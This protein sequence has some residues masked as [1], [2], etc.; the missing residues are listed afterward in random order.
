MHRALQTADQLG[1]G[2]GGQVL[3]WLVCLGLVVLS[4]LFSGLTLGLLG[5][6]KTGLEIVI[7]GGTPEQRKHAKRLLPL[8]ADGNRLLC[9]L[10][11]GNV[12]VNAGLSIFLATLFSSVLGLVISTA[13]IVVFGEILPQATCS[14]HALKIGAHS[15]PAVRFFLILFAPAAVPLGW[16]LDRILG[17]D[18]GTVHT[19][20]E[21]LQYMQL[22]VQRGELDD[23]SGNVMKGALEM[24]SKS[25]HAVMTPLEDVYMLPDTT[26]LSFRVVRE[27]FE[28][29]FSRVPIFAGE[30]TRIVGLLFVKDLIFVDPEDETPI[31]S[32]LGIFHR[33]LQVVDE[34]NTLDDVLRIFKQGHGHLALVRAARRSPRGTRR[35]ARPLTKP[36]GENQSQYLFEQGDEIVGIVTLEDIVEEII[37]DEIIDETDVFVDVDNHVPVEGRDNFDFTKLR[38]LDAEFVTERLSPE[39]IQAV[40]AHLMTNVAQLREG[41][42]PART[43]KKDEMETLV[44]RSRVVDM[45]RNT[46]GRDLPLEKVHSK[47]FLYVHAESQTFATLVLSGKLTVLAGNDR[48]RSEAGP[49]TVLGADALVADEDS[50]LPDFSAFISTATVRCLF[51]ARADYARAITTAKP[52]VYVSDSEDAPQNRPLRRVG[53]STSR[54]DAHKERRVERTERRRQIIA[55]ADE[56]HTQKRPAFKRDKTATSVRISDAVTSNGDNNG[57]HQLLPSSVTVRSTG[58]SEADSSS[59]HY[60]HDADNPSRSHTPDLED[61]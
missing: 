30:R 13:L 55:A 36:N 14:R 33:E 21:M 49:W 58:T 1:G 10:L 3:Q 42:S 54:L 60:I 19:R 7:G 53:H 61:P 6:D 47:D 22:H 17:V 15:V 40:T 4:G 24:T 8:R 38:R 29:G 37:G 12:V 28:H 9:T 45:K 46:K 44:R 31:S 11:L 25:V 2:V 56:P 18:V 43:L 20:T 48:F 39:E 50:F 34:T 59:I 32:L 57:D 27:I 5:L 26:T 41:M 16:M 23:E 51:I 35:I 52:S